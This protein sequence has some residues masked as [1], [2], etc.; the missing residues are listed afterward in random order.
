MKPAPP[1]TPARF[2]AGTTMRHVLV[3]TAAMA[4]GLSALFLVDLADV[5]F[6][7]LL[8]DSEITAAIGFSV[9][10]LYFTLSFSIGISIAMGALV[11]RHVGAGESEKARQLTLNILIYGVCLTGLLA[12]AL[13]LTIPRLLVLMGAQDRV[14]ALATHYLRIIIPSMPLLTIGSSAGAAL[15]AIGQP[16]RSALIMLSGSLV[17]ASLDPLFIFVFHLDIAGAALASVLA[18]AMMAA[19]GLYWLAG[20]NHF[21]SRTPRAVF[22]AQ[23]KP[24]A[25]I[26]GPVILTNIAAPLGHAYVISK[27]SAYGDSVMAGAAVLW[28]LIPVVF[29]GNFALSASIGPIIGQNFGARRFDRVWQAYRDALTFVAVYVAVM[30]LALFF[31]QG[32]IVHGFRLGGQGAALVAFYFTWLAASNAFE[33][34]VYA[35]S[36]TF[37]NLGYQHLSMVFNWAKATLGIIPFVTLGATWWGARGVFVGVAAGGLLF[38]A[39][40]VFLCWRVIRRLAARASGRRSPSR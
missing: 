13:W 30:A 37:N 15:R 18:R 25:A 19:F 27:L 28:R 31:A 38:A 33:G 1:A 24:F 32:G 6:L 4:V 35:S 10:L 39:L 16:R 40:A 9:P 20:P 29:A 26:A 17:N 34:I 5:Y 21:L 14:L 2:V 11:S 12:L 22:F 36:A 23:F 7:S 3:M 8:N